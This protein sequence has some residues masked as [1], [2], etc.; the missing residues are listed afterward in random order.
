[1]NRFGCFGIICVILSTLV[2]LAR[3]AMGQIGRMV[4]NPFVPNVP[5]LGPTAA[6]NNNQYLVAP[7]TCCPVGDNYSGGL[8]VSQ[9]SN[10][11]EPTM[12][13][14]MGQGGKT[15]SL[16]KVESSRTYRKEWKG[17]S[18]WLGTDRV[19]NQKKSFCHLNKLENLYVHLD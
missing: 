5:N 14:S 3:P 12:L 17:W 13:P 18:D 1:M 9:L 4:H 11:T 19:Q 6:C 2:G 16:L 10:L 8:C 7:A 15:G